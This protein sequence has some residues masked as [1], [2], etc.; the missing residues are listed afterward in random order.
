M[1]QRSAYSR[2][3]RA[4]FAILPR[5]RIFSAISLALTVLFFCVVGDT[6]CGASA[7]PEIRVGTE[8]DFPPYGFID[9]NGQPA[10][11]SV[12]LIKAVTEAMGLSFTFTT[13][14]WDVIWKDLVAGRIDVLPI[15]AKTARRSRMVEFSLPHTETYDAFFVRKGDSP[16][17]RID[18]AKGKEIVVMRSDAAHH[19]LEERNFEG[20]LVIVDSIPEGLSLISS[21]KHDAF[22]CSKLIGTIE[23]KERGIRGLTAGPIIPDYK[24]VFSFAVKKGDTELLEKLNQGLLIV[25]YNGEYNRIYEKWLSADDPWRKYRKYLAP[26]AIFG[27]LAI[28]SVGVWMIALQ[29]LVRRR[30]S[31]L[32]EANE[33]LEQARGGLEEEVARKTRELTL[34]N[35]SL[36]SEITERRQALEDL[37]E[38]N[39]QRDL[40][41][42]SANM[43]VWH[44]DIKQ[45]RRHFDNQVCHLL[46]IVPESFTGTEEEFFRI[47]HAGDREK[48]MAALN[49]TLEQ[50]VLYESEY[51]VTWPDKSIH[52]ILSRGKLMRDEGGQ[53]VKISGICWD[54]TEQRRAEEALRE[55]EERYRSI[56]TNLQDGYIRADKR[57][58]VTMV[59]PSLARMYGVDSAQEMMGMHALSLYKNPE[60][61]NVLLGKLEKWGKVNDH[62]IMVLR[63]DGTS[64]PISLNAQFHYDAQGQVQGT[65]AFV[66]DITGRKQ[67]EEELKKSRA[68]LEERVKERT[69]EL[70]DSQER[71]RNLYS[72]LNSLREEERMNIARE[73]HDDLGQALTGLKMDLSWIS[74]KLPD[75]KE[76]LKERLTADVDEVNKTI[77]SVKR[78][79][80]ELRPSILD[81]LG[82]AAAMDWQ[83]DEFQKRTGIKCEM[84]CD[85]EDIEVGTGPRIA[86]FRV[87]QEGLTNALKHAKATEVVASLKQT[88]TGVTLEITDNGIGINENDLLKTNCFGLLG[89]RERVHPWGGKVTVRGLKNGGTTV[90]VVIPSRTEGAS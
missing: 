24:R 11:F 67:A 62:E 29:K 36:K 26:V 19:A 9:Y 56:V 18:E 80:T 77:Q 73:I 45:N 70:A 16:P 87:F 2:R 83:C 33:M 41:L 90:K 21:G 57:G 85:P 46:G 75:D 7:S 22:L 3:S 86:L 39:T 38:S 32:T 61:R 40:A 8:P 81:H 78:L 28:V 20:H 60:D 54:I 79:C 37:R 58:V 10:G 82:L 47:V 48:V 4:F 49:K 5:H 88:A 31:Q 68:E 63:K 23:M 84:V 17:K 69:K 12:D 30:T 1:K 59:S 72:H 15:V 65:E 64:F 74:S 27:L 14:S 89:M 13:G 34:A 52:Y 42:R 51:H 43:G 66:R 44:W 71:L 50:D 53:P 25:K 35:V 6:C 55:S 76:G